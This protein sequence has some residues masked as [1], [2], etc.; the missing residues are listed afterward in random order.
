[1]RMPSERGSMPI[2]SRATS[3]MW[4]RYDGKPSTTLTFHALMISILPARR[5]VRTAA[6]HDT[7]R[8]GIEPQ[9]FARTHA[10]VAEAHR[11]RAQHHVAGA[12]ADHRK[13]PRA[14]DRHRLPILRRVEH[15]TR[16][17]SGSAAR[18]QHQWKA[19]SVLRSDAHE[20]AERRMLFDAAPK[21]AHVVRRHLGQV[22]QAANVARLEGRIA[23]MALKEGNLPPA[24]H[25]CQEAALLQRAK[26]VSAKLCGRSKVVGRRRVIA[27]ELRKIQ[28]ARV[29]RSRFFVVRVHRRFARLPP[30]RH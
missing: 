7:D 4:R 2:S 25:R 8:P 16:H 12:H 13:A 1:M 9:R 3:A 20:I 17:A 23:P 10:A 27:F 5:R 30:V 18:L 11:I 15:R 22:V 21:I 29:P 14:D 6:G 26:L 24:L 28:R 19:R